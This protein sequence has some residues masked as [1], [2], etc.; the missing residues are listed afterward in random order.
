MERVNARN[1]QALPE[2]VSLL[3]GDL[4]FISLRLV[5]TAIS[6]LLPVGEAV[7]LVKPQFEVGRERVGKGGLV[8]DDADREAALDA[9]ALDAMAAGFEVC[10][11]M[12]SPVAGAKAGNREWLLHLRSAPPHDGGVR[13]AAAGAC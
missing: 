11:R 8:R 3:V 7:L 13:T 5:L 9:V 1:L 6:R 4:S 10:G 2:P 12:E